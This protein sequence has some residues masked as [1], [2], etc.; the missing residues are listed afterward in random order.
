MHPYLTRLCVKPEVQEFFAPF[1][2][3][4]A[5]GN[6]VFSYGTRTEHYGFAF[7]RVPAASH[8]WIAGPDNFSLARQVFI[9]PSAMEAI[10]F[11]HYKLP[12]FPNLDGLLFL[13]VGTGINVQQIAWIS[14]SLAEKKY[15]FVFGNDFLGQVQ[16]LKLA[17]GIRKVAVAIYEENGTCTVNFRSQNYCLPTNNFSLNAIE[18]LTRYRF[19]I[20]T[21]VPKGYSTF[22]EQLKA[23]AF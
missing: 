12:A 19:G 16:A 2:Q 10:S 18:K 17:A 3:S 4:D 14:S 7:H 5:A 8:L 21:L 22:F 6:M 11:L 20:R 15:T 23:S 1:Y 13:A 9:C